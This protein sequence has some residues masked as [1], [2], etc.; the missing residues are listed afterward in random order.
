MKLSAEI[1]GHVLEF[2]RARHI[3]LVEEAGQHQ[4][5]LKHKLRKEYSAVLMKYGDPDHDGYL[6]VMN[7]WQEE[8]RAT[9][10]K[11]TC[12]H[13]GKRNG[14]LFKCHEGKKPCEKIEGC[15]QAQKGTC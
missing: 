8:E 1:I 13:Y 11:E 4:M 9:A 15:Y 7:K 6:N 5:W 14:Y 10:I 3:G 12:K 2:I